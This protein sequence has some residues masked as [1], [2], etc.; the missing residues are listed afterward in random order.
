MKGTEKRKNKK[1][2]RENCIIQNENYSCG[3]LFHIF[4]FMLFSTLFV[5]CFT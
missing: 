5:P 2:A 3:V 4:Y 1:G